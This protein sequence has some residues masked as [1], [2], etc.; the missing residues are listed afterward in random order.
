MVLNDGILQNIDK[1]YDDI[2]LITHFV[3]PH[4][5]WFKYPK[6]ILNNTDLIEL[7]I[8]I[9]KYVSAVYPKHRQ[10][11]NSSDNNNA[12]A[13]CVDDIVAVLNCGWNKWVR[14]SVEKVNE[15]NGKIKNIVLWSIDHGVPL[16][17]SLEYIVPLDDV[18]LSKAITNVVYLGG[19]Y[20]SIPVEYV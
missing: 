14:A 20:K 15:N 12:Y 16:V 6:E 5:F 3:N 1:N 19:L 9:Q 8:K 13:P 7:E 11:F 2:I 4:M 17:S 18:S 10:R